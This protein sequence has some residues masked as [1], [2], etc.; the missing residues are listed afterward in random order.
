VCLNALKRLFNP[1]DPPKADSSQSSVTAVAQAERDSQL[2]A[3]QKQLETLRQREAE[4]QRRA[5]FGGIRSL[6]S[7][8]ASGF[9][10]NFKV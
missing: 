9:G 1:P 3:E 6:I 10:T 8:L 5:S 2:A 7:G 4:A